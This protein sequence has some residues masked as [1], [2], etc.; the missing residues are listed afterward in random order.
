LGVGS[1]SVSDLTVQGQLGGDL[2]GGGNSVTNVGAVSTDGLNNIVFVQSGDDPE[3]KIQN[4]PQNSTIIFDATHQ[5][6]IASEIDITTK[7]V[8]ILYANV[9]L[10][11]GG[12]ARIFDVSADDVTISN[13]NLDGNKANQS[14][15]L[16]TIFASGCLN[17]TVKNGR[18]A[19]SKRHGVLISGTGGKVEDATVKNIVGDSIARDCV[20]VEGR[21]DNINPL[22]ENVTGVNSTD[23][24]TVEIAD[25]VDGATVK[26]VRG[27]SQA[28]VV[29]IED[30][31]STG[32]DN[33]D[34]L[35]EDVRGESVNKLV[36]GSNMSA[37]IGHRNITIKDVTAPAGT[38]TGTGG[39]IVFVSEASNIILE[40]VTIEGYD[41]AASVI[42]EFCDDV[43]LRNVGGGDNT[44]TNAVVK[45]LNCNN[46]RI[47]GGSV[48][49]T[50][51]HGYQ[52]S[53]TAGSQLSGFLIHGLSAT[54][55][56][57]KQELE[58]Q[59]DIVDMSV[60]GSNVTVTNST[61]TGTVTKSGNI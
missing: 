33:T 25:G 59:G 15:K 57:G 9:K 11:A 37:G 40:N 49:S 31:G 44:A 58:F 3:T 21:G 39:G 29:T 53:E 27:E 32:E 5:F 36:D 18:V 60:V 26:H 8:T 24:G 30:H 41:P 14:V 13:F 46:V 42:I 10:D 1:A 47:F 16:S 55:S 45:L 12:D 6:V 38:F 56:F 61:S 52:I 17:P 35:V 54:G 4:A 34:L 2:D 22:V 51:G 20:S 19:N 43:T 50:D 28:Y 7:G 48:S 23:R